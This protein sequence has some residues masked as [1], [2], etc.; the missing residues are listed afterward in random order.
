VARGGQA[1]PKACLLQALL[2]CT[3]NKKGNALFKAHCLFAGIHLQAD[4]KNT[5]A[6]I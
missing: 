4:A 2:L 5:F 3:H 6:R 1:N